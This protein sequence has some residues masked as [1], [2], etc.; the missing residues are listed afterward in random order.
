MS[1]RRVWAPLIMLNV[2]HLPVELNIIQV[3]FTLKY[4]G[5]SFLLN[6][7]FQLNT[8]NCSRQDCLENILDTINYLQ[9]I[10]RTR[11]PGDNGFCLDFY[12]PT[13]ASG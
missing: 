4:N 8:R 10:A 2:F 13:E 9:E 6:T 5:T 11:K 3:H 1:R 12:L 7:H